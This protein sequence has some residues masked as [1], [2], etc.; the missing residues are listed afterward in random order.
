MGL[1]DTNGFLS[2]VWRSALKLLD[3]YFG[4][5]SAKLSKKK[6]TV[7]K[8]FSRKVDVFFVVL[9]GWT[10]EM[11]ASGPG[12]TGSGWGERQSSGWENKAPP[13]GWDDGSSFKGGSNSS[14]TW[15]NNKDER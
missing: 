9:A 5:F 12:T 15:S 4:R 1:G 8:C 13:N 11:N 7:N 10:S 2:A 14:N 6:K 3:V